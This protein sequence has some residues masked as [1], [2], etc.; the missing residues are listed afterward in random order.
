MRK[1]FSSS[2]FLRVFSTTAAVLLLLFAIMYF[3]SVPFIQDTVEHVEENHAQTVL[4]NVYDAVGK[5]HRDIE[6]TRAKVIMARKL[7]LRDI[8]AVVESRAQGL[9]QQVREGRLTKA[10]AKRMLFDEIRRIHYGN[11]D[12]VWASDYRSVLVAHPDPQL[13]GADF[14]ARQD[15]R[16]N[17]IV[18]PMVA[19][20][21]ASGDGYYSYWWRRLGQEQQ[22]EKLSYARHLPA[23]ELVIGTGVYVDDIEA[24]LALH[25]EASI[26]EL[27]QQLRN[28]RLA[29][30]GYV[31][32]LDSQQRVIIHPNDNLEGKSLSGMIDPGS[33]RELSPMLMA[34]ADKPEGVRYKWDS[35]SDPGNYIYDKISWV[36]YFPE[37]DWYIG[38]S[39]YVTELTNSA[40]TLGNRMLAVFAATLLLS[41][42][43]VYWF[44]DRLVAPLKQLSDTALMIEKG[45]LDV[46]CPVQR[47][48]E[49]GIVAT[50]VNVMV[51][52]LR[53]NIQ[54]LDAKVS[55]RT[56]E[57]ERANQDL[58]QL[59][60]LKSDFLSTVSHELRT[61]MT[62]II[63]FAKLVRKK[64]DEAIFPKV[65]GDDKTVRV[66][67]QVTG[68]IDIIIR[69][70]ERLTLLI[71]DV[72][73]SAKLDAGKMEWQFS[74]LSAN[75]LL[76]RATAATAPLAAQKGLALSWRDNLDLPEVMGD[77]NRLLQVLINLISNAVKFT[78]QGQIRLSAA[79]A[80][81]FIRFS[82]QDTGV[83]IAPEN[84][85]H[86]FDKFR[87]IAD[88][89][90]DK[91]QGTG[92]GLSICYQ[93]VKHHGGDI[94]VE[95]T[96]GV[97]STFYFTV[98]IAS[99][100][101]TPADPHP[102]ASASHAAS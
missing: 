90:T 96:P 2:L 52:R 64:L 5:I 54:N 98:P 32:I 69:E 95:S 19:I 7:A 84:H 20:A 60:Q 102:D 36:R 24:S 43:L 94:G 48:D 86:V 10:Q 79:P 51:D 11:N 50:A 37:F 88:T 93:I 73:D 13:N 81:G 30:T 59:D 49:I 34:A 65:A 99:L 67:S 15:A 23:F 35:P 74:P 8:I 12:Y 16:G 101:N 41:I 100:A 14:S 80:D 56:A 91:P 1:L 53:D 4:D 31:Y 57:L 40:K 38:S 26:S 77:K 78:E 44:V 82:V 71:G 21:R 63:G 66:M 42:V 17:L 62:S 9:E 75:G 3:L 22:I 89:L 25:R 45:N 29:Q 58:R 83:G 46:R 97:G 92:L 70:S 55:S 33:A 61:P 47:E 27:R 68:N 76:E 85:A 18:P 6:T 87:Q 72:L 28:I 39:V